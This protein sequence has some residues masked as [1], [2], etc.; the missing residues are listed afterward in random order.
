MNLK[1]QKYTAKYN[2][3]KKNKQTHR[4]EKRIDYFECLPPVYPRLGEITAFQLRSQLD[5]PE[6]RNLRMGGFGAW[7][8]ER[9]D[10]QSP[11]DQRQFDLAYAF[12]Q[13]FPEAPIDRTRGGSDMDDVRSAIEKLREIQFADKDKVYWSRYISPGCMIL[14]A[15]A[16]HFLDLTPDRLNGSKPKKIK[17]LIS[18]KAMRKLNQDIARNRI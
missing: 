14:A 15:N 5:R 3:Q 12:F 13:C 8:T 2:Q 4:M 10:P 17:I 11:I 6:F 18:R 16:A 7:G 9:I 1:E